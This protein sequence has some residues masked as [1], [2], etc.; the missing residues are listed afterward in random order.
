MKKTRVLTPL[1]IAVAALMSAQY[2]AADMW[3]DGDF[4]VRVGASWVDPDDNDDNLRLNDGW[5]K[6]GYDIDSD[7]TWNISGAW[8]PVEHWG[9]ELM[10]IGSTKHDMDLKSVSRGNVTIDDIGYR[11]GSFDA[12]YSNAY[13]N[14]YPLSRDCMGQPYVG[15]GVNYTDFSD[16]GFSR[17]FNDDLINDGVIVTDA[18]VGFQHSWGFT[19]QLGVDFRFGRDSAFLVNAAVLYIDADT[20]INVYYKD[21]QS[22]DPSITRR[23]TATDVDYS[24]WVFNLGVGYS[25]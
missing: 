11:V 20:D 13:V 21:A 8:L 23:A 4:V 14:W 2:A 25:F 15:I 12:S 9:V 19:G 24:P 18:D 10:Y 1:A 16:E 22:N 6:E 5:F 3:S 17:R 7:T